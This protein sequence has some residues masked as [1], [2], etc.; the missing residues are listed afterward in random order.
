MGL[1]KVVIVL[2]WL[3]SS[4]TCEEEE[5][6]IFGQIRSTCALLVPG[7]VKEHGKCLMRGNLL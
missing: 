7:Q 6:I 3:Y 5:Y 2:V 4:T 1:K